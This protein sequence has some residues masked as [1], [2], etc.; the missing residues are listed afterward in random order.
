M[1][2]L[3]PLLDKETPILLK[4]AGKHWWKFLIAAG[5]IA[6]YAIVVF[7]ACTGRTLAA[8]LMGLAPM[9]NP[10]FYM[11]VPCYLAQCLCGTELLD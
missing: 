9:L 6:Y 11:V 8:I 5:V 1:T 3:T 4:W 2:D 7:L 10:A